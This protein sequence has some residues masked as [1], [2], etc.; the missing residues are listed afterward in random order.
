MQLNEPE[1]REKLLRS[2]LFFAYAEAI[3]IILRDKEVTL[4]IMGK[5]MNMDYPQWVEAVDDV[6]GVLQRAPYM[7]R[8]EVQAVLDVGRQNQAGSFL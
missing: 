4:K 5:N 2:R 6:A 7:T 3:S 1:P 8:T